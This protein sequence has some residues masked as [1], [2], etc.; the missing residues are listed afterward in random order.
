M[1]ILQKENNSVGPSGSTHYSS[2][3]FLG[4][5]KIKLKFNQIYRPTSNFQE[6]KEQ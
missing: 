4:E 3:I 2:E 5:K 1:L 6:M